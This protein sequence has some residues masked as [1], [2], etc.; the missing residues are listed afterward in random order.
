MSLFDDA[1]L[2]LIPDGAKD[3]KLYSVKPTDGTG[4]FTFTRGSNLAATRV[5]EN[6]LIEKG[7][8]NLLKYSEEFD[9]PYYLKNLGTLTTNQTTAPDG[10]LTA[11]LFTKTSGVNTVSE[12]RAIGVYSSAG[13]HTYSIYVK[14]NVGDNVLIRLDLVGNT[15]NAIFNF[16]T[17]TISTIGA[18]AISATA[19]ELS[20]GWF[21]L[22][23]TGNVTSTA[24]LISIINLFTNPTNDSVYV[25]GAQLEVGLV[26]TDYIETTTTTAQ[27]GILE[28]LPRIDYSGSCPS[29]LLEPQRT[30]LVPHSEYLNG[31]TGKSD[32]LE[33][34]T[35]DTLSPEG[36]YN[37]SKFDFSSGTRYIGNATGNANNFVFSVFAKSGTHDIIQFVTSATTSFAINFDLSDGS[38]NVVGTAPTELQ[39]DAEDYGNGWYRIWVYYDNSGLS[40]FVYWWLVDSLSS[41]RASGVSTSGS[42]YLFGMQGESNASYPTSYIPTYGTSVTRLADAANNAIANTSGDYWTLFIDYANFNNGDTSGDDSIVFKDSSNADIFRLWGL[43]G[44]FTIRSF[45]GDSNG[46]YYT[47]NQFGSEAKAI[48]RY[49]G[50]EIGLFLNGV[51][52]TISSP[53]PLESNWNQLYKVNTLR[54]SDNKYNFNQML[55]FP[56]ALSDA[57]CIALTTL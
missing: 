36:V 13:I 27:A 24:W 46:R 42:V 28:D 31:L 18:N 50:T 6:G 43:G 3:G 32:S 26:A 49:D 44:G 41:S 20:D 54:A 34:N 51:K 56:E 21:R 23:L 40:S 14:Q 8:E 17:K 29:L 19:T 4:D 9:N 39:Y 7:R 48:V 35:A 12:L 15:A 52:Q 5:D 38:S 37:A 33:I 47:S 55:V 53:S 25:W 57:D 45:S 1:S 11:D 2:V 10:S 22:S 16:S 30:N